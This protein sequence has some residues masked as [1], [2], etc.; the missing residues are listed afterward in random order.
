MS[1]TATARAPGTQIGGYRIERREP[2]PHLDGTYYELT[3]LGAGARHIHIETADDNNAFVVVLP[4]PPDDSTGVPHI[5]EHLALS[6]SERYPVKDVFFSM[7]PRSLRTFM[8]ASTSSDATSYYYS[9]R[10][11]K[12]FYNLMAIY[13]DAVFFPKL[14]ELSFMQEG[15]RLEFE[16]PG[17][18]SSGLRYK[19]VVFN[20]MKGAM[21][22]PVAVLFRATGRALFPDLTYAHNSG[23][24][25]KEIPDLTWEGLRAFH[26][27]HYHPSNSYFYTYGNLPLDATLGVIDSQVLSRFERIDPGIHIGEQTPFD[28]PGSLFDSY[29][30]AENDDPAAKAQVHV[31][32][33]VAPTADSFESLVFEVVER[34]LLAGAASPLRKALV[35]SQLGSALNDL[36][37]YMVYAK[38]G[39]FGAGLKDVREENFEKV[40]QLILETL[41]T[42]AERGIDPEQVEAAIHR[43]ELERREVSNAGSPYAFKLFDRM[44]AAYLHG[45]DP[46]RSL[47]F[48]LDLARL[49]DQRR[50]GAFLEEF[51]LTRLVDNPHRSRIVVRGDRDLVAKANAEELAKLAAIESVLSEQDKQAIVEQAR[52]LADMQDAR[53]DLSVLPTLELGD[54]PMEFEDIP[55]TVERVGGATI[56]LFPQP[57]NAISYLDIRFDFSGLDDDHLELLSLFAYALTRSGAGASNYLE[58]AARIESHTGGIGAGAMLR[59]PIDPAA[60]FT[61]SFTISGK[62]LARNHRPFVD[63]LHDVL[64]GT[65]FEP[66]RLADLIGQH[67]GRLEPQVLQSGHVFAQKLALA[68]LGRFGQVEER[69]NGL[70]ALSAIKR[71]AQ[72]PGAELARSIDQLNQ[73]MKSLFVG[74]ADPHLCLTADEVHLPELRTM[75]VE[76]IGALPAGTPVSAVATETPAAVPPQART[77]SAPVAYNAKVKKVVG[78][79]HPDAPALMVL[80]NYLDDKYLLQQIREKGGAYGAS[81][82]F[83]RE[84]GYFS[85]TSYRDPHIARTLGVWEA[86]VPAVTEG[87]I[88]PNDLKEAILASCAAV[89]PLL[90]P[91]TKGRSRFFDDLAGYTIAQKQRF[92]QG[93]LEVKIE[94]LTRVATEHLAGDGYALATIANPAMVEEANKELG[95]LFEV[96]AI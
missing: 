53:Q 41:R 39:M 65:W 59:S 51:I 96:S 72:L 67:K 70:S 16:E 3:H 44:E 25:P 76:L 74:T 30:L 24:D 85:F 11:E 88:R 77:T 55:H 31:A 1:T 7:N 43:L 86:A 60:G 34:V 64:T 63:I 22:N 23:G 33:K 21:A 78:F 17:D 45:G 5:L 36:T 40:E 37:G 48:D 82:S 89:D 80:A 46:N 94:D 2:L 84:A 35:D 54:I 8:N 93:L 6:G 38:D 92:K 50:A 79:T 26:A 56:G 57:T 52:A 32:W 95:D 83:S 90:S 66:E 19:G 87:D 4:T 29:P 42:V 12:D 73:M 13:L 68:S 15:H 91:D 14:T 81:A 75:A 20:E 71:L 27:R 58:L 28:Q 47:Q 9:T 10:N 69:V 18:P 62:A 61:Q 49:N